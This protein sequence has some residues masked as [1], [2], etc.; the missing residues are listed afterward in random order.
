MAT[1]GN[2][3]SPTFRRL[4]FYALLITLIADCVASHSATLLHL[5]I[6]SW[7]LH[8]L[9]FELPLTSTTTR[10]EDALLRLLHGPSFCGSHALFA[11]YLFTLYA[12][13]DMEFDLS[14]PGRPVW[15]VLVRAFWLHAIPVVL[16]WID[17]SCHAKVL[18][19]KFVAVQQ[20]APTTSRLWQF[21]ACLGGYFAM[22]L[23]WEQVNGDS[24]GTYNI[25]S[26]SE[27]TYV[28]LSKLIGILA[29]VVSFAVALRP[30]LFVVSGKDKAT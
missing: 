16:H 18:Q 24:A 26:M 25:K 12:N 22:G 27:E 23:T 9:Y 5:T 21:W 2:T 28:N 30:R 17:W 10:C 4:S 13:P 20:P 15:L 11:M 3:P 14:P 8:I 1:F 29:C 19:E 7:C 6:W